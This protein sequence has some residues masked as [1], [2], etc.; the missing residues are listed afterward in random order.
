MVKGLERKGQQTA[1]ALEIRGDH[2]TGYNLKRATWSR[3]AI[4]E[5]EPF[6]AIR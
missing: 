3:L 1:F 5:A 4:L 2:E 6:S